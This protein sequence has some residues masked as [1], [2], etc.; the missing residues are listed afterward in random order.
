MSGIVTVD[1]PLV[2]H[3]LTRLRD[4]GT[5]SEE[6]RTLTRRLATLLAYEATKD[7]AVQPTKVATPLAETEGHRLHQRIGLIPILRAGLG[8][9]DA[10]IDLTEGKLRTPEITIVLEWKDR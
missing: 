4:A 5:P 3:H 1:H 9:V 7:L 2:A 6:F 8:M 10:V